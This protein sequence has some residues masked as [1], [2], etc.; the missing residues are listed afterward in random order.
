WH[1]HRK[2]SAGIDDTYEGLSDR[3]ATML[4]RE[5]GFENRPCVCR[6]LWNRKRPAILQHDNRWRSGGDHRLQEFGLPPREPELTSVDASSA[7]LVAFT[8]SENCNVGARG[9]VRS[10]AIPSSSSPI[11]NQTTEPPPRL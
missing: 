4:A 2:T 11:P 8:K 5:P 1:A 3:L 9:G 7:R 10:E 6:D